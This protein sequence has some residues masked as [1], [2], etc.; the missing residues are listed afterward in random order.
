MSSGAPAPAPSAAGR[1]AVLLVNLGT[2]QA[3]TPAALRRYLG[4]FLSDPRVIEI[5]RWLWWPILHGVILRV[6]PAKSAAKYRSIWMEGGSPLAVYTARQ[7]TLLRGWLGERGHQVDVDWAMRYGEPSLP[8][9][10]QRMTDGGATRVLIVP[11]YPQYS[12]ATT[13]SVIDG[14]GHW[15]AKARLVPEMRYVGSYHDDAGYIAALAGEV[16]GHWQA[17]GKP[18]RLVLSF[19]GMPERTRQLGDPYH[20]QC[21]ATARLLRLELRA[22]RIATA[23]HLPESLRQGRMAQAL[24]RADAGR[25]GAPGRRPG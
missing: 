3:P 25:T 23:A 19:H 2:P 22:G 20:D 16:R 1:T 13:A 6:R 11:L 4:E 14:V 7:A 18:D 12:A 24:H 17:H 15:T 8:S 21:P 10:L 5:P 9:V